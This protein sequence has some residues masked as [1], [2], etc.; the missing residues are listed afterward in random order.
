MNNRGDY[1]FEIGPWRSAMIIIFKRCDFIII[2]MTLVYTYYYYYRHNNNNNNHHRCWWKGG[3]GQGP[4][5]WCVVSLYQY[6]CA[7]LSTISM[8]YIIYIEHCIQTIHQY[9]T[10]RRISTH[11]ENIGSAMKWG[12]F[13]NILYILMSRLCHCWCS[14]TFIICVYT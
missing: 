2:R 12:V 13:Q 8:P 11:R 6:I 3:R 1:R 10:W 5:I 7:S 4:R 14:Y 9:H